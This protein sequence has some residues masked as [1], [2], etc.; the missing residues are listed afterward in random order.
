MAL[1]AT[2]SFTRGDSSDL[3]TNWDVIFGDGCQIVSNACE[4]NTGSGSGFDGAE[5]WNADSFDNDQYAEGTL[6]VAPTNGGIGVAVRGVGGANY[7]Y[8]GYY[9][10]A[11]DKY[12][13]K[14]LESDEPDFTTLGSHTNQWSVNDD[15]RLEAEGTTI[16]PILN[17]STD[18]DIGAKTDSAISSGSA[19]VSGYNDNTSGRIDD[20]EGGNISSVTPLSDS[21]SDS[22]NNWSDAVSKT[23]DV[24]DFIL[25]GKWLIF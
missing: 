4:C 5:I 13:F 18:S 2:D 20:W 10:D 24:V 19:G 23:L 11:N 15:V 22:T 6:T 8:Y 1:P 21:F 25:K 14:V 7:T 9:S 3:G 12:L 17:A 16:T